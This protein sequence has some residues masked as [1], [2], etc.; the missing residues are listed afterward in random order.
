MVQGQG[1]IG[2]KRSWIILTVWNSRPLSLG[3]CS[4]C[5]QTH[6]CLKSGN[7]TVFA[8][9]ARIVRLN[10][11]V[12]DIFD[13]ALSKGITLLTEYVRGIENVAADQEYR[14]KNL[15]TEWMLKPHILPCW[16]M[17]FIPQISTFLPRVL[18]LNYLLL[19]PV[20]QT[21]SQHILMLSLLIGPIWRLMLFLFSVLLARCCKNFRKTG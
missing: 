3:H 10:F 6:I 16:V 17:L 11:I 2:C 14:V 21:H 9:L 19:L 15:D 5:S 4:H 8:F 20:N 7:T 12:E 18:M 1:V 13:W